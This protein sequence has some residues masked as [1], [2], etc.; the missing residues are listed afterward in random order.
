MT[1]LALRGDRNAIASFRVSATLFT[2]DGTALSPADYRGIN[3]IVSF[4]DGEL[5][6]TVNIPVVADGI[7]E[8]E[9]T[10]SVSL[11]NPTGGA[12]LAATNATVVIMDQSLRFATNSFVVDE[13]AGFALITVE[14]PEDAR[15]VI[16]VNYTI[17]DG[18]A[19]NGVDFFATNGSLTFLDGETNKSWMRADRQQVIYAKDGT[20]RSPMP[21]KAI[22]QATLHVRMSINR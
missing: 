17:T 20:R 11:V 5:V 18:V 10:F 2:T 13:G 22:K 21:G 15:G 16:S 7:A 9:E 8:L 6:K 3:T 12:T 4:A 19:N 14:R 1:T